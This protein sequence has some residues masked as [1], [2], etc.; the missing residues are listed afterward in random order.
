MPTMT[1]DRAERTQR[2]LA[3]WCAQATT[4]HD[5]LEGVARRL[6]PVVDYDASAWLVTDPSTVLFTD[7]YVEG[8]PSDFCEPWYHYEFSVPDVATFRKLARS[9]NPVAVLS[10]AVDGELTESARWRELLKPFG[11]GHELRVVFRDGSACWGVATLQRS[12]TAPDFEP[13]EADLLATVS[14]IV[15]DGLRRV[16]VRQRALTAEP[17]G[18]GLL[19]IGPDRVA[20]PVT[21]AGARWLDALGVPQD[22]AGRTAL[23]TLGELATGGGETNR[24]IRLRTR[25]GRWATLHA[26]PMTGEHGTFAVIIEPSRPADIGLIAALAYGLSP[27]ESELVLS[28]ARGESTDEIADSLFISQHTVRGH[29][30]TI[31]E[32]TGVSSR[33]ELVARLFRDHYADQVFSEIAVHT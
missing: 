21:E 17:D 31:F 4:A 19:I 33:S 27:R 30:K 7:G 14:S 13:E 16:V 18:P 3:R 9:P 26:E 10:H 32:K 8:F 24:R 22:G 23:L 6:R 12:A 28:L 1:R 25:D 20:R 2:G 29:L 15:A 5:L 11:Y